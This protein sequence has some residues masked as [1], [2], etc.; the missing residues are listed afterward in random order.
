VDLIFEGIY[1]FSWKHSTCVV[2]WTHI[3]D[4]P[5][6]DRIKALIQE[7]PLPNL[8]VD[9]LGYIPSVYDYYTDHAV[10]IFFNMSTSEGIPVSIMEAESFGIPVIATA[11][12]GNPE[13]VTDTCGKLI[14][15]NPTPEEI[16]D[17]I[18]EVIHSPTHHPSLRQGA[19]EMWSTQADQSK[20]TL[21][22]ISQLDQLIE[23]GDKR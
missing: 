6:I 18:H 7:K 4:G 5:L 10:D 15:A 12:G 14:S 8:Q 1:C 20:N 17:A 23:H 11:V 9:L 13:I 16:A 19:R 3:G 21:D 22:F 2:E